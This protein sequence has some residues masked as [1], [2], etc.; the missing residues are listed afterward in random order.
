MDIRDEYGSYDITYLPNMTEM[1]LPI[2]NPE[3]KQP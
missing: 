2:H 1:I 3:K